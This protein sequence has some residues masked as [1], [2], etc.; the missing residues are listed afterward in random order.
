MGSETYEVDPGVPPSG[1]GCRECLA[2]ESPGW[3]WHLRRCATCGHV[4]CCDSSPA[5]HADAHWRATGHP[6]ARSFEPGET[7]FWDYS[8]AQYVVGPPLAPPESRPE[9]QPA[10]GPDGAVPADWRHL[11]H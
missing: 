4:G 3:W 8:S 5:Q 6:V 11:L 2:G 1:S 7:W 10:P 9:D